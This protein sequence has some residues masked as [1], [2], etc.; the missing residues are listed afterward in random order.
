VG[1]LKPMCYSTFGPVRVV[2]ASSILRDQT[3]QV[4]LERQKLMRILTFCDVD[5]NDITKRLGTPDYS[6]HFVLR[7]FHDV[8]E[9]FATV[10]QVRTVE[11]ANVAWEHSRR[12]LEPCLLLSFTPPNKIPLGLQCPTIPVFAWEYPNLP[13]GTDEAS[14]L[15]DPRNDWASVLREARAAITL[16]SHTVR[17]VKS[18]LGEDFRI[19]AF[20]TPLWERFAAERASTPLPPHRSGVDVLFNT[21]LVDSDLLGLSADGLITTHPEDGTLMDPEMDAIL[22]ALPPAKD[23]QWLDSL[24]RLPPVEVRPLFAEPASAAAAPVGMGWEV[25]PKSLVRTRLNGVVYTAVITPTDGRKNWENIISAFGW[26]FRDVPDATLLLKLGG[27]HQQQHHLEMLMVL[28]KLSPIK[29]RVIALHGYLDEAEYSQLI[30][31]TTYYVNASL[32][33]GLC[34]PLLEF[35]CSGVPA[36]APDHT[37]MADYIHSDFA[38]V[39]ESA[40]SLPSFWPHGDHQVYRTSRHQINWYSLMMAYRQSYIIAKSNPQKYSAMSASALEHMQS[41]CSAQAISAGLET[42]LTGTARDILEKYTQVSGADLA[43]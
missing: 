38:F 27:P 36:I 37:S 5:A 26:A 1:E 17:A 6:Y 22:P 29:C 34:M 11:E 15:S 33:E 41:Y 30:G 23:D 13:A 43:S 14:W 32:C 25:P 35:L 10:Q 40:P 4:L 31:A 18:G 16:S 24:E 3:D 2:G 39:V 7:A 20:P 12:Q 28:T 8:L 9:T 19:E 42:F 21:R